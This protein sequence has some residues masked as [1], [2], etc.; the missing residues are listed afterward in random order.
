M[1]ILVARIP[2]EGSD[3]QGSE[4]ATLLDLDGE[5]NFVRVKSDVSYDFYVQR[6]QEELIVRG[7]LFV[8]MDLRCARCAEFFSTTVSDS[9]FLRTYPVSKE[10]DSVDISEDMREAVLLHV[11]DFPLC[12][13]NLQWDFLY[14]LLKCTGLNH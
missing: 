8:D 11:P 14:Q 5:S 4:P 7:A 6:A 3:S 10:V 1:K 12:K 9:D 2:E 13:D